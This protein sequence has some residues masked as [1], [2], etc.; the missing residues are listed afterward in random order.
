MRTDGEFEQ[1]SWLGK[2]LEQA[3]SRFQFILVQTALH[4]QLPRSVQSETGAESIKINMHLLT[5]VG[6]GDAGIV[7]VRN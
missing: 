5:Y 7:K 3:L 6:G 1:G 2:T 4:H